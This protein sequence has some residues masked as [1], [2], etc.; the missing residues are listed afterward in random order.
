M[1][2]LEVDLGLQEF[3][4]GS[5]TLR[6]NPTDPNLYQ[7]FL[8]LEPKLQALRQELLLGSRQLQDAAGVLQLLSQGDRKFKELL[9][10]VFGPEN[11][12]SR[13]LG[14]VNLFSTDAQG[15][16]VAENLLAALEPVL[17][18]GAEQFAQRYTQAALEKARLR[19]ENH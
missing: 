3:A 7:R 9:T 6:F 4:L 10:W 1:D 13:L 19:R 15:R 16:S 5:G 14:G 11:D 12:F 2:R 17:T 8:E 18:K